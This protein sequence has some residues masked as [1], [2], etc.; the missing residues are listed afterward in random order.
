MIEAKKEGSTLTGVEVQS[1]KYSEGLPAG[2]PAHRRP[3]PFLYESTGVETHFTNGLD[4]LKDVAI[5]LPPEKEQKMI[6]A[7]IEQRLSIAEKIERSLELRLQRA[8]RLRQSILN[9]AFFGEL[10]SRFVRC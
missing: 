7:E 10:L 2:L 4:P 9:K 1:A 6:V 5:P 8:E 3:L